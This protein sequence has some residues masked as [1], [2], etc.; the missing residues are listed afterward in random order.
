MKKKKERGIRGKMKTNER[1]K[2]REIKLREAKLSKEKEM[3]V[4]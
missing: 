4:K 3:N 2:G 1:E